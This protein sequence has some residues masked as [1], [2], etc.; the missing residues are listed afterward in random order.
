MY[1]TALATLA[2]AML[3]TA[4]GQEAPKAEG[5]NTAGPVVSTSETPRNTA[6]DTAPATAEPAQT[7]GA[8]SFTEAQAQK[9]ITDA[10]YTDVGPLTQDEQGLWKGSATKDGTKTPVSVD[11]KGAVAAQ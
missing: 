3:V 8:N 9:A 4:C 10:G 5:D 11:Y 1:R 2:A 7:P 6:I